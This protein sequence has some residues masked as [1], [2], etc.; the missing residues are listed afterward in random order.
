MEKALF[1]LWSEVLITGRLADW[2]AWKLT[3]IILTS[4]MSDA[5][6][7][8]LWRAECTAFTCCLGEKV[9]LLRF[10]LLLA[11]VPLGRFSVFWTPYIYLDLLAQEICFLYPRLWSTTRPI[12]YQREPTL[13]CE[14]ASRSAAQWWWGRTSRNFICVPMEC[15]ATPERKH[16]AFFRSKVSEAYIWKTK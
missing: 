16:H 10:C 15:T 7:L 4:V 2:I 13:F 12:L 6:W 3:P 11:N 8:L 5:K 1:V 9:N 14:S